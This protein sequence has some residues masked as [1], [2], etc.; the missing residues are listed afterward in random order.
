MILFKI[1]PK[2]MKKTVSIN[3]KKIFTKI[4]LNTSVNILFYVFINYVSKK[5]T[6]LV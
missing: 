3:L 4:N 5:T 6:H 2:I 1:I